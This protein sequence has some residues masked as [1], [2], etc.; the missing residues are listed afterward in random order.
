L[1]HTPQEV[2]SL[3]VVP[4]VMVAL[5]V[6]GDQVEQVLLESPVLLA[7]QL[8]SG[9]YHMPEEF[10]ESMVCLVQPLALQT[11]WEPLALPEVLVQMAE[12]VAPEELAEV[13]LERLAVLAATEVQAQ[14]EALHMVAVLQ[15]LTQASF[16]I[17]HIQLLR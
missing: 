13:Q 1:V 9:E 8:V 15:L 10:L 17:L 5:L 11:I 16:K 14:R 6:L 3:S 7:V 12:Q 4:V 2:Q